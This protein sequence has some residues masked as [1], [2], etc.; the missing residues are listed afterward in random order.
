[1]GIT[2]KQLTDTVSQIRDY[3]LH[4]THKINQISYA[5]KTV[6]NELD[7]GVFEPVAQSSTFVTCAS[8]K[9]GNLSIDSDGYI[10]LNANKK[11]NVFVDLYNTVTTTGMWLVDK[12]GKHVS[13]GKSTGSLGFL[14]I[15]TSEETH[16]AIKFNLGASLEVEWCNI[17][18]QEIGR[19]IVIDPVEHINISQGIEDMPVGNI[20]SHVGTTAPKHYLIC[21]GNE[22][23]IDQYPY[24]AQHIQDNFGIVNYFGGDGVN[25]FCVPNIST[26]Y[27]EITP[28]MTSNNFPAPYVISAS[29]I[30]ANQH[31]YLA[32]NGTVNSPSDSWAASTVNSWL[33]ID[34]SKLVIVSKFAITG[35]DTNSLYNPK[36][37]ILY[38]SNDDVTYYEIH[39]VV[40]QTNWKSKEYREYILDHAVQYRYYKLEITS[41]NGAPYSAI[42]LLHFYS[43]ATISCIKYEPT[44]FMEIQRNNTNY[45]SPTLYSEEER[46]IGSWVNGKPLYQQLFK[47]QEVNL[48]LSTSDI[49]I[50]T[51]YSYTNE[52]DD[53]QVISL[54]NLIASTTCENNEGFLTF[55][56]N[57]KEL[58]KCYLSTNIDNN[59][60]SKTF[61][62]ASGETLYINTGWDGN[63]S[64]NA[65][66]LKGH[67]VIYDNFDLNIAEI[68]QEFSLVTHKVIIYTKT[69]DAENSF[70]DDMI[71]DYI[72]NDGNGS[73]DDEPNYGTGPSCHCPTYTD[74]E[75]D[76]T[77]DEILMDDTMNGSGGFGNSCPTYTDEEVDAAIDK[78]LIDTTINGS[79]NGPSY[80]YP[81]YTDE[82]VD[83]AIDKILIDDIIK[84]K[85]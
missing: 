57:D 13:I 64:G 16:V 73:N 43:S 71:K 15:E 36:D 79:G 25:T 78:I 66:N 67:I 42:S 26:E 11:Y 49:A 81:T 21:D 29:S 51:L 33:K 48:S 27:N 75:V 35:I 14:N 23:G 32:F 20:I 39:E 6:N 47:T 17:I 46:I 19:A 50:R 38:G 59:I 68:I 53:A 62:L 55:N 10:I 60:P 65:W 2:L 45:L 28:I 77:I 63:H 12:N 72:V 69:T 4:K 37:F 58:E 61:A 1:M 82:E 40:N 70:T 5:Q 30:N 44:Y 18:V 8:V 56:I 74:E 9:H 3:V 80:Y 22:Y 41:N 85:I 34:F 7:Y 54:E 83:T 84:K 24:L 31:A 76:M 52:N